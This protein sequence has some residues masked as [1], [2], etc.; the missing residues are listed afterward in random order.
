MDRGRSGPRWPP[1]PAA[2]YL[3][4]VGLALTLAGSISLSRFS[5]AIVLPAMRNDLGWT[6]TQAGALNTINAVGHLIGSFL[7]FWSVRRLGAKLPF[8][9]SIWLT[10]VT[11]LVT[12]FLREFNAIAFV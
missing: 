7:A 12:A 3:A 5:Y 2:G 6:Y 4:A 11:V 9:V 8:L 1:T 10:M